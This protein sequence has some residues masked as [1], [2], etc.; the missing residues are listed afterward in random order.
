VSRRD[1]PVNPF[2][3]GDLALDDAFA[4]REDEIAELTSDGLNGQNVVIIAPRRFGKTSLI[5]RVAHD[6]VREGALTTQI[7]LMTTPTKEQLVEQLMRAIYTDIAS[8]LDRARDSALRF[9]RG[10]RITPRVTLDPEDGSVSFSLAAGNSRED[11][12]ATLMRLLELPAELGA[13]RDRSVAVIF[14]EFQEI[15]LIDPHL[16]A[17]MRTVFQEQPEVS[18]IYLGSKRHMMRK[19]FNDENEPFWRSSKQL[20]LG[21]IPHDRFVRF[22]ERRFRSSRRTVEHTTADELVGITG[23]H[24]YGTQELAYALW[25]RTAP[26]RPAA[27]PE[28]EQAVESVLRWENA[29]FALVWQGA[30]KNERLV[31]QALAAEPDA[32]L[33]A[34]EYRRRHKLGAASTVQYAAL[35]LSE[36]EL[37]GRNPAGRYRIVEPFLREWIERNA[38]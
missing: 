19:I 11:V 14:D 27:A 36:A 5:R 8:P 23:G 20:E 17:L 32:Q 38:T 25:E 3:Y 33:Q 1:R 37:I 24:P 16:P 30:G 22:I 2:R 6:L 9:V 29:H 7:N 10:L 28:L 21:P 34:T 35:K 13:G 31:L 4:D 15:T 26:D 12:D 18:H